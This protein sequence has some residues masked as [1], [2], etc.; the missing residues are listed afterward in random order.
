[1]QL[2]ANGPLTQAQ[3][4]PVKP[5]VG[6][7]HQPAAARES[8]ASPQRVE[9][10]GASQTGRETPRQIIQA[11]EFDRNAPRGTYLNIIV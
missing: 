11:A 10:S 7:G 3:G 4:Q 1:M 6:H 5:A 9:T 8:G 2:P